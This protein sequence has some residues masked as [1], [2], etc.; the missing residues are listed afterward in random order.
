M[1]KVKPKEGE[2]MLKT[3]WAVVSEGRIELLESVPLAEG[4]RVLVTLMPESDERQF[5]IRASESALS[6]IWDNTED[7]IYAEL[8]QT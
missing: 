8:L 6:T 1:R 5:W 3:V 7:D 2:S 4:A